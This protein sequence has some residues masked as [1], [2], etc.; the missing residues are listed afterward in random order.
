MDNSHIF[1]RFTRFWDYTHILLLLFPVIFLISPTDLFTY[2]ALIVFAANLCLTAYG[3]M[4]N[5]LEDAVD[6]YHDPEKRKRNPIASGEITRNQSYI[7][8]LA[9]LSA[10]LLML[11]YVGPPLA[12]FL[13]VVFAFVGFFY[14]WRPLRL[15]ST[16]IWDVISHVLFLGIQ[17][18]L[19][20]YVAFR[21][22][23][24]QVMPFLMII[25]PF[26]LMNE[27]MHEL[28]DFDVD[29]ETEISNTV[30]MFGGFNVKKLLI[31]LSIIVIIG[32][33]MVVLSLSA[34]Y[35]VIG[36]AISLLIVAPAIYKMNERV[37]RITNSN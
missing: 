16:P 10:G 15:K 19:I 28:I 18:L 1:F 9:L 12:L 33:S 14:S 37:M 29:K 21:P 20:T 23:D 4:Y 36:L 32:T 11:A 5:D 24:L 6:D 31:A 3:Y 34:Q 13:G 25:I 26:S 7:A 17:Q 35:R 2:K 30:Q 27:I 8:T 22:L